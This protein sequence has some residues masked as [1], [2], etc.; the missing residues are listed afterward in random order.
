MT[1]H[2]FAQ[3]LFAA[4]LLALLLVLPVPFLDVEAQ[5]QKASLELFADRTAYQPG[6]TVR[7]AAR[8]AVEN[9]WHINSHQ[10]TQDYLIPT[11]LNLELPPGSSEPVFDYPPDEPFAFPFETDPVMVYDGAVTIYAEFQLPA[12]LAA[13]SVPVN[14]QLAY[15]ACDDKQCL[16]P[17]EAFAETTLAVGSAGEPANV[18]FFGG[19]SSGDSTPRATGSAPVRQGLLGMLLFGVLGG[20][21][22]NAM[23]CVLPV[24]SIKIFGLVKSAG[25][26]RSHLV[27]GA[28]ATTLGVLVSFWALAIAAIVA[29]K[30]G[31]AVGWGVQFQ[32]PGFVAF[33]AVV[34]V[35]FSLNMWGLFEIPLPM[36]LARLGG[37]GPREGLAGHFASGLF[38]TLMATP[39]SAPFLGTA[40][41]FALA[42]PP[43]IILLVFTSIGLGLALPYLVLAAFPA[44]ARFLPKPGEWMVTFRS[45]MGFLLAAAAIWLF[46]VLAGQISS[47]RVAFVQLTLLALALATWYASRQPVATWGRR[48]AVLAVVL[49]AFG[50]VV[51]AVGAPPAMATSQAAG[52]IDWRPFDE[53]EAES[54]AADGQMVFVDFTA[55][56]C[57]T[58]KANER[59]V[60][61]T[62][63]IASAFDEHGVVA[64]KGDW[65]N[66][67][68]TITEFL[69]RHGR[70]AVPFYLLYR[71]GREPHIFG[72][73]LT[74]QRVLDALGT[75]T[76]GGGSVEAAP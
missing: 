44:A 19:A 15:Q 68:D 41:G 66:R 42:E 34:V 25:Q 6:E 3:R 14:A 13:G 2:I 10:P 76:G 72:E 65:T 47:E 74:K 29:A 27:F 30:V 59:V 22:L 37:S 33:L 1:R 48:L 24:L 46:Y 31:L 55:D 75:S 9:H 60:I 17:T 43:A 58:C 57:L 35:L 26:G 16:P 36:A 50:T 56:W 39:C 63:T 53:A 23:P 67:D 38:A 40:V 70:S 71:P 61:E 45:V 28:L 4:S 18:S 20:L 54:L 7:L 12:D 49:S 8:V 62:D 32:Q 69:A 73:L 21:I 5:P 51:L 64:M 11:V 52:L